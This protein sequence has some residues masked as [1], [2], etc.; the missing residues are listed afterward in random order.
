MSV[1]PFTVEELPETAIEVWKSRFLS[2]LRMNLSLLIFFVSFCSHDHLTGSEV[3][4]L[5]LI[6]IEQYTRHVADSACGGLGMRQT[7]LVAVKKMALIMYGLY[8]YL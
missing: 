7:R 4:L 1:Q 3:L 8:I 6:M 2:E 5:F